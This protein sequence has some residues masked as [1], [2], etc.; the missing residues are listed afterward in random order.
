ML[1]IELKLGPMD[2]RFKTKNT[3]IKNKN[4]LKY[5]VIGRG[6]SNCWQFP[7]WRRLLIGYT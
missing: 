6:A 4:A 7:K 1:S 3:T 5:T 2:W